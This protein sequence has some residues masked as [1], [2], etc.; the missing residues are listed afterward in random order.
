MNMKPRRNN[1]VLIIE[2]DDDIRT[3]TA[4]VLELEGYEVLETGSG[5]VGL[6]T[7]REKAIDLVVLDLRLPD[8]DGW[9]FLQEIKN[10]PE[11]A[12]IPVVVLT[13]IAETTQ[14]KKTLKMGAS[15]YLVKPLSAANLSGT[16]A[17]F[18]KETIPLQQTE[19]RRRPGAPIVR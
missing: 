5:A 18:L 2:D 11:L 12:N 7:I 13:A 9:A 16:V 14:R 4:R 19:T 8:L 15:S 3:F 1:T 10:S 6:A 17:G